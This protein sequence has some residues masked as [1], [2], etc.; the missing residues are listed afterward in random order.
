[1]TSYKP[2][3]EPTQDRME[4]AFVVERTNEIERK[5]R[6]II[7]AYLSIECKTRGKFV[8]EIL[9]NNALI[10]L[11]AKVKAFIHLSNINEWPKIKSQDFQV[12]MNTR[13]AFAHNFKNEWHLEIEVDDEGNS[14]LA[15]SYVF[16]E[17]VTGSGNLSKVKRADALYNFTQ[18]Y[19]EV[20][21]RLLDI[22]KMH[23]NA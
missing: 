14:W 7:V 4:T 16:I 13:N 22:L 1:M 11:S 3:L 20:N 2:N 17:S 21:E 8:T 23:S 6:D 19:A 10:N 9:L 15:D 18:A 5:L 12:I